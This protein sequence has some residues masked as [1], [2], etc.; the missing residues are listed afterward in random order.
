MR[1]QDV[2]GASEIGLL[3]TQAADRDTRPATL[4]VPQEK[5]RIV[6]WS[7]QVLC[8]HAMSTLD[9]IG[10]Q[11]LGAFAAVSAAQAQELAS[12]N[13]LQEMMQIAQR[14]DRRDSMFASVS[15]HANGKSRRG[16]IATQLAALECKH[17]QS[18]ANQEMI[19]IV[20]ALNLRIR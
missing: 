10:T 13:V 8:R 2:A 12:L 1:L 3:A 16:V 18:G 9:A 19:W 5:L 7:G 20:M 15:V 11:V 4:F 17:G 6:L 14:N